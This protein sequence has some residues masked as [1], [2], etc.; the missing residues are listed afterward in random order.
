MESLA[1]LFS[2]LILLSRLP[3]PSVKW[4]ELNK[5]LHKNNRCLKI[6]NLRLEQKWKKCC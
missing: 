4:E 3:K 6:K 2:F 1:M 5:S